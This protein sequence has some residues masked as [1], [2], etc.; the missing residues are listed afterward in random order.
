MLVPALFSSCPQD[1]VVSHDAWFTGRGFS[2]RASVPLEDAI[3]SLPRSDTRTPVVIVD[4]DSLASRTFREGV[5]RGMRARGHDIWFMTWVENADDLF[6]AFNTIADIVMGPYHATASEADLEDILTVSD[7]FVPVVFVEKGRALLRNGRGDVVDA[8]SHLD[9][10]GFH[11][12]CV[13]DVDGSVPGYD[14]D[15]LYGSFPSTVAFTRSVR[16]S[17][18]SRTAV[19]PSDVIGLSSL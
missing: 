13:L 16:D 7:S 3:A 12:V 15:R 2:A 4:M 6:D 8:V 17:G 18:P 9:A 19:V 10:M 11:R 14:W 1:T 5:V